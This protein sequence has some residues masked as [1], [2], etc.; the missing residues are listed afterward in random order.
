MTT[1][2]AAALGVA[3]NRLLMRMPAAAASDRS[4]MSRRVMPSGFPY[5]RWS[6]AYKF[7]MGVDRSRFSC[8]R[9][10]VRELFD[11]EPLDFNSPVQIG[12]RPCGLFPAAADD[13]D[14][15]R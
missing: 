2:P 4:I 3:T 1:R 10:F 11:R 14:S 13:I 12:V 15:F 9:L 7:G 6:W 8:E 5:R